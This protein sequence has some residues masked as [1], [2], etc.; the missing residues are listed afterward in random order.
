M[1]R[2]TRHENYHDEELQRGRSTAKLLRKNG[3][4]K[5]MEGAHEHGY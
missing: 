4:V 2:I 3:N 5:R 1:I